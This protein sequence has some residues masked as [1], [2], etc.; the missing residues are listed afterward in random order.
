V[1]LI[2]AYYGINNTAQSTPIFSRTI[3]KRRIVCEDDLDYML[4]GYDDN[5]KSH[6][7]GVGPLVGI[8]LRL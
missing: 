4:M 7:F 2:Q 1:A 5:K 3:F 6:R 8:I